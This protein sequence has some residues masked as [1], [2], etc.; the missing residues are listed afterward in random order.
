MVFPEEIARV[1]AHPP[2]ALLPR[3]TTPGEGHILHLQLM[4]CTC[5]GLP[6]SRQEVGAQKAIKPLALPWVAL[7]HP[8]HP[9][10]HQPLG[11]GAAD[12]SKGFEGKAGL[13]GRGG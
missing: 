5:V 7:G 8:A 4:P 3:K 9:H 12:G 11:S 2:P 6:S 1:H 13:D 10:P